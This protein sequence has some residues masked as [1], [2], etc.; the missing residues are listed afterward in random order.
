LTSGPAD[1]P[2]SVDEA[3]AHLR[4]DGTAEDTLIAS[5]I[6]ASRLHIETALG[7]ALITQNWRL[8]LD[9]WPA[10]KDFE[11]PIRPLQSID[12]VRV[13]PE[14]GMATV[15][16][17]ANYLADT[18]STPP[19]FVRTAVVWKH[20]GK[21][22]NGIEIDLTVGFGALAS[23]V[24]GP[25]RQALLLLVAHWYENREPITVG[26]PET[27]IPQPVSDLVEAYRVKRI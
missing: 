2:V 15:I 3:K 21:P 10:E 18:V 6:L 25:L 1:E 23:E 7:L 4:V 12:A 11:L 19:R 27:V 22:A 5:L 14:V 26:A 24:P 16:D 8:Y 17:P 13:L 9:R 20:P